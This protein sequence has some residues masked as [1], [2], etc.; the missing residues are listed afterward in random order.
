MKALN[1]MSSELGRFASLLAK[2]ECARPVYDEILH[3]VH[4]C[5]VTPTLGSILP[6]WLLVISRIPAVNFVRWRSRNGLE[7]SELVREVVNAHDISID[8]VIWFE[9]GPSELG[10][11]IG[12][13]VDQAH[14]HIIVDAPFSFDDFSSEIMA[15]SQLVWENLPCDDAHKSVMVQS[16][17]LV[18]ASV[19]QAIVAQNVEKVGSQF[20]RRVVAD[21]I[22][23]T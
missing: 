1:Q 22:S 12:C 19:D 7:P 5:V 16:S 6:N 11:T 14:L 23:A 18:A 17:Y 15:A 10:S 21:L 9:H 13:G 3:E 2:D 20:F 8:R 4:G